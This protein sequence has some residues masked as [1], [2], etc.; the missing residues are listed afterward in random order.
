MKKLILTTAL[1]V[2]GMT[3]VI[4]QNQF[5]AKLGGT[6]VGSKITQGEF[7]ATGSAV[8]FN[9]GFTG[10]FELSENLSAAP[11]L[12]F[13]MVFEE[14][15]DIKFLQVPLFLK[16]DLTEKFYLNGGP[17]ITYTLE[18]IFNDFT[19]FNIGLG[20]GIGYEFTDKFYGD[21]R[22]IYQLNNYYTGPE[23]ITS[24]NTFVN[25]GFGF[26]FD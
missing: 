13:T 10:E 14:G 23:D 8:G 5:G 1:A 18:E 4:A 26:K 9:V 12:L 17:Q 15:T 24:R 6:L 7:E 22:T 20:V 3:T 16:Y 2:I 21:L 19:K 11:E 25:L